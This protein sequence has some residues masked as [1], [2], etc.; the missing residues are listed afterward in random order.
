MVW[1]LAA[2][3][4]LCFL[5][6]R[7]HYNSNL[8]R[9]DLCWPSYNIILPDDVV[10]AMI[11]AFPNNINERKHFGCLFVV[12]KTQQN[13]GYEAGEENQWWSYLADASTAHDHQQ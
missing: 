3:Y 5:K 7:F 13:M 8:V 4:S 6:Q 10:D 9:V 12:G 2:L 1:K 11:L